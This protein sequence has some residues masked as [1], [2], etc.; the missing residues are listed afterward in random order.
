MH[1]TFKPILILVM[2]TMMGATAIGQEKKLTAAQKERMETQLVTYFEKLD[3]SEEQKPKFEEI[4]KRYGKQMLGLKE[5][6]KGRLAK[7]NEF[8]SIRKN[9]NKE[10]KLLLSK[11][12]YQIYE[13]VQDEMQRKMKEERNNKS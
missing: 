13:E 8:K 10:M 7:Y 6:D 4:T 3:L 9:K 12:Q 1:K 2:V 5:S 11:E